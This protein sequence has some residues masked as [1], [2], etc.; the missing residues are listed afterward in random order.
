MVAVADSKARCVSSLLND[1]TAV[2]TNSTKLAASC[3][4]FYIGL[5]GDGDIFAAS[6]YQIV[7]LIRI[8]NSRSH[9]MIFPVCARIPMLGFQWVMVL[10]TMFHECT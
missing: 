7:V 10:D 3:Y 2:K 1:L 4:A 8:L 9:V 5:Y 6:S